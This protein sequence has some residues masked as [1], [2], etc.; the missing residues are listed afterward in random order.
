MPGLSVGLFCCNRNMVV[1]TGAV[2]ADDLLRTVHGL[3]A[4]CFLLRN[5]FVRGTSHQF[6]LVTPG[7]MPPVDKATICRTFSRFQGE[8]NFCQENSTVSG[9]MQHLLSIVAH[10]S[11]LFAAPRARCGT[12][13]DAIIWRVCCLY[14]VS[15]L[16][17]KSGRLSTSCYYG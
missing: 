11:T 1:Y 4:H 17:R 2:L 3:H 15:F 12:T 6:N 10:V 16:H 9:H 7:L 14:C 8:G 5:I 13:V